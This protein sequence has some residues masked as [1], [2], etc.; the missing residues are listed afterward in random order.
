MAY[1]E[2]FRIGMLVGFGLG[3]LCAVAISLSL[4]M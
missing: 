1:E 4:I 2:G 3:A